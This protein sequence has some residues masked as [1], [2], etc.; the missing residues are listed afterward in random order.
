M[1]E[2]VVVGVCEVS[3]EVCS[4]CCAVFCL[5]QVVESHFCDLSCLVGGGCVGSI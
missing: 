1:S 4:V 5:C 3:G 2:V